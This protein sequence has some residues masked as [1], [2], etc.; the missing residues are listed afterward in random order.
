MSSSRPLDVA[1]RFLAAY[2]AGNAAGVRALAAPGATSYY[3][4][5]GDRG[6]STLAA[7]S[8]T[9]SR[10]PA[11]FDGFAMP[12]IHAH[13]DASGRVAFVATLNQGT[14]RAEVDGIESRGARMSCPHLFIL[15]TDAD[16][17]IADAEIWCDEATLARQL[18][19]GGDPNGP[20]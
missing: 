4:P 15:T 5:W 13:E 8:E 18:G 1:S 9:W 20:S 17:L 12:V 10:Y 2:A 3:V 11:A 19:A 6:R 14:Q 7:A 16:G